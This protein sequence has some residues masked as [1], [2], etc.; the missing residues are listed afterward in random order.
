[1][2]WSRTIRFTIFLCLFGFTAS[3][4]GREIDFNYSAQQIQNLNLQAAASDAGANIIQYAPRAEGVAFEALPE[5]YSTG[6]WSVSERI[7]LT[8]Y[9]E[10]RFETASS[11]SM[12]T[13]RLRLRRSDAGPSKIRVSMQIDGGRF[14]TVYNG[15]LPN[16]D[17]FTLS[18]I[19]GGEIVHD[20]ARFRLYAWDANETGGSLYIERESSSAGNHSLEIIG[21]PLYADLEVSGDVSVISESGVSCT[22]SASVQRSILS[23][24]P[25][26][27]PGAC[28]EYEIRIRNSSSAI[29][30]DVN[31]SVPIPQSLTL[32][33][34][35]LGDG[36]DLGAVLEFT[37]GCSGSDCAVEVT[38]GIILGNTTAVIRILATIN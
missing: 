31:V 19:L 18:A 37:L 15:E 36:W 38:D 13:L 1:M 8:R 22:D 5:A 30:R 32:R 27:I 21:A 33:F 7:D 25:A 17:G 11:F 6:D 3:A 20:S 9:V 24:A 16:T 29:A 14:V 35:R 12:E 26:A 4:H 10:W 34:A 23:V 2:I 28:V